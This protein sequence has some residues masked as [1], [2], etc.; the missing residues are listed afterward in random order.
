[1]QPRAVTGG[2]RA[3]L[4]LQSTTSAT[5]RRASGCSSTRAASS[6]PPEAAAHRQKPP[7]RYG[8][9]LFHPT[10]QAARGLRSYSVMALLSVEN[11]TVRFGGVTALHDVS[12]TI[13]EGE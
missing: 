7:S 6:R 9:G 13:E 2:T 5:A 1:H 8:G 10:I 11:V 4:T 3:Q 12:L